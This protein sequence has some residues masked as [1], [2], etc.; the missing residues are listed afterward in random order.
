M[1]LLSYKNHTQ[2][3]RIWIRQGEE[4]DFLPGQNSGVKWSPYNLGHYSDAANFPNRHVH[5]PSQAGYIYQ[6]GYS[7]TGSTPRPYH[8]VNPSTGKPSDWL[9]DNSDPAY[10][11]NNSCPSSYRVPDINDLALLLKSS[12]NENYSWGYYA[13]GWFDRR[14]IVDALGKGAAEKSAVSL[15]NNNPANVAYA[16]K[17]VFDVKTNASIFFPAVGYRRD[18]SNASLTG[19]LNRAGNDGM[20]LAST[21]K[22]IVNDDGNIYSLNFYKGGSMNSLT[23]WPKI[24]GYSIR[25]VRQ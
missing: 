22:D 24:Y 2:Q 13:D 14:L 11:L 6:W 15:S 4:P 1:V 16:G 18:N 21:K 25:C 8:P 12:N 9:A 17:M 7:K 10:S 23:G 19:E 3:H 5:Y 20:Y